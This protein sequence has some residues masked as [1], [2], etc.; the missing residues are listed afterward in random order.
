MKFNKLL[1][2]F[3][4]GMAFPLVLS[5]HFEK[6]SAY[7]LYEFKDRASY[8][9]HGIEVNS[10]ISDEGSVLLK[11]KDNFLPLKG[12]EN[13]SLFGKSSYQI[14]RGGR[15]FDEGKI[16]DGVTS[17]DFEQ[18][19][20]NA[21]FSL[22]E[23]LL[24][25]YK[26]NTKSGP[27]RVYDSSSTPTNEWSGETPISSYT[28]DLISTFKLYDD[29]AIMVIAREGKE[30]SDLLTRNFKDNSES[31]FT[32]N[33]SLELTRNEED[34][35]QLLKQKFS[36][37]IIV[38][39]S[40]NPFE[41]DEFEKEDKVKAIL[42]VGHTGD[43][44][45]GALGRILS[46]EVN[47]SGRTVNTWAR[48]FTKDP[49]YQNFG[50]NSQTNFKT[51]ENGN[52][53]FVPQ[54]T[55]F[56]S[57]GAPMRSYGTDKSYIDHSNPRWEDETNKVVQIGLM[58]TR[59]APYISYEEGI[60]YDYRYYET[61]YDDMTKTSKS[62]ADDWYEGTSGVVYP[63]GYGL[64]YTTFTQ[65]ITKTNIKRYST[66]TE[67]NNNI[68]VVVTVKNTGKVAG[69]ETVQLYWKAP[70]TN[71]E[72]EKVSE[73]LCAFGKTRILK[74]GE[75]EDIKLQFNLEDVANYD[76]NDANKNNFKG[77]ELDDGDYSL[78]LNKN[79][80]TSYE[81]FRF[82]I[83]NGGIKFE[84]STK[85]NQKIEN[86][87]TD[88]GLYNSLPGEK[89][90]IFEAT[91]RKENKVIKDNSDEKV[92]KISRLEKRTVKEGSKVEDFLTHE[93][94]LNDL[95]TNSE[96][97]DWYKT[98][99][100]EEKELLKLKQA[101]EL[102]SPIKLENYRSVSYEDEKWNTL[103][104]SLTYDDL[105]ALTA[106]HK[107]ESAEISKI[108][109]TQSKEQDGTEQ[110]SIIWWVSSPIIAATFNTDLA[111]E[112]GKCVAEE[113]R[114]DEITGWWGPQLSVI[115]SP[116]TG[117]AYAS[118]SSDPL[119]CGKIGSEVVRAAKEK[120]LCVYSKGFGLNSQ[121][122]NKYGL[123]CYL[124]EQTL[125]EIY[126][127]PY[128]IAVEEGELSGLI[129]S[130]NRIGLMEVSC[131][132]P[133]LEEVVRGEWGF[134]GDIMSNLSMYGNDTYNPKCFDNTDLKMLS[135]CGA[136]IS[137][138]DLTSTVSCEKD[139]ETNAPIYNGKVNYPFWYAL[140][141]AAKD[142]L[143][144]FINSM[145][146]DKNFA[147]YSKDIVLEKNEFEL[148]RGEYFKTSITLNNELNNK[149]IVLD[150]T[151]PLPEG[152]KF[153]NNQ[154]VGVPTKVENKTV[155][156]VVTDGDR[157]YGVS[158]RFNVLPVNP[159]TPVLSE[160]ANIVLSISIGVTCIVVL[161]GLTI[162]I[163]V[164]TKKKPKTQN[165][166]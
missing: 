62:Q 98:Y 35:Y 117:M 120:G 149:T 51:D 82:K 129:T 70:Y 55:M 105:L 29:A 74:P 154:I 45:A 13:I 143:Y 91:S 152:L 27:G 49:T 148:R 87:F 10:Q 60:Y 77:Y 37:I 11:N 76:Y 14:I 115:R 48:D 162:A 25:F 22:N 153:E 19:L 165:V 103:L 130:Y 138:E 123:V 24:N 166:K 124:S 106:G 116:F 142:H 1:P 4:I 28:D 131:N 109:K 6:T 159:P 21:G 141:K 56:A 125:R 47:P 163:I 151:T 57:N 139:E 83:K 126:L 157:T 30:G 26:D 122:T 34:L 73:V 161:V 17:I 7:F 50:D 88:N 136:A 36:N 140:R 40:S 146:T 132:Y 104:D 5:N 59:P 79:A 90:I 23:M 15:G 54:D 150:K 61:K 18:S 42:W 97:K 107:F 68:E 58:G 67:K 127:K 133:L 135:G 84:N 65:T 8:I 94:D 52:P 101:E 53:I 31:S 110:L 64:S 158:V 95:E 102:A 137:S 2:V 114:L 155:N 89:D 66:L 16:S 75:K 100:I 20:K 99:D 134:N 81:Q 145:A 119:L 38:I 43:V 93:F 86:R 80:H 92:R 41:C 32:T 85:T 39:N 69:K 44:G 9:K 3:I 72:I 78:C 147:L 33:H 108:G 112:Q 121:E 160:A 12:D 164:I 96:F 46:G 63:F 111:A 118:Y 113:A 144:M 156:F 128:Q 71:G